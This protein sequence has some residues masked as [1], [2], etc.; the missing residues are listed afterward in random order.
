MNRSKLVSASLLACAILFTALI[1]TA[2][3]PTGI[4]TG[5]VTDSS[6]AVVA[7]TNI[8]ITNKGTGAA[9]TAQSNAEGVYS[10]PSLDPG[11]YEVRAENKG[12]STTV[13]AAGV[14]AGTTITVNMAMTVGAANEVVTVEAASAQI[15]YESNT[16]QGVI[17]RQTIQDIPLNGRSY[18][19]LASLE[20]GVAMVAGATSQYNGVFTVSILGGIAGR[21]LITLD[22]ANIDDSVQ[23]GSSM[24]FSQ[25]VVQEFQLQALNSDLSTGITGSGA[26]NVVTRSG[27]NDF[28]GGAYF[29]FRDHNMAAYPGL[30]RQPLFPDPFFVRRNP[31]FTLGGPA[32]KDKLFFFFNYEYQNQVQAVT[33]QEDLK[34]FQGL[35]GAF[36]S[37]YHLDTV[38]GRVDYHFSDRNNFFLRYSHDGNNTYGP[39]SGTPLPSAWLTN[40]NYADQGIIGLTSII[41]PTLVNDARISFEFWSNK[42]AFPSASQCPAPC[43]GFGLPAILATVG[44]ST[45][46][47]GNYA[48]APQFRIVRRFE[49]NDSL[50]WQKGEHRFRFGADLERF[51]API[52]W[53]FCT[54]FCTVLIS[55]LAPG[56]VNT[57]ADL[58]NV[59]VYN[60]GAGIFSGLGI[61]SG[62]YP[63]VYNRSQENSNLR[64]RVYFQDTWKL[65]PNLTV[66]YGV[67]WEYESGLFN[68]DLTPPAFLAPIYGAGNLHPTTPQKDEFQPVFGFAWSPGKSGKTVIRGGAGMYWETNYYFEKWRGSA[69]YGPVG[70]AR[71]TLQANVLSNTFPGIVNY[72]T[73][74]PIPVGAPLPINQASNLTFGQ[75]ISLYNAQIGVLTQKFSPSSVPT[76]GAYSVSGLDVAKTAIELFPPNYVLG[77]SYQTSLGVQ[78]DLGHDLVITAD[79]ARRQGSHFN[80]SADLDVNHTNVY[81]GGVLQQGIIPACAPA[82]Y[83]PGVECVNGPINQWMPEGRSIYEGLLI[84]LTKR[85]SKNYQV[86]ASYAYQNLNTDYNSVNLFNYTESYGPSLARQ[87]LNIAAIMNLPYGF[88]LTMNTQMISRTPVTAVTTGV[89]LSGTGVVSNTPLPG[90]SYNC[91]GI[92]CSKADLAAAVTQFNSTYA[93]TKAPNGAVIPKY[94]LPSDYQLGDPTLSQDFRLSR[95]FTYKER[96][97]LTLL[98]EAFNAFNIANLKGYTFNLDTVN[99][100]PANQTFAFGQ[101]TQRALQTFGSGGPRAFQ[102]GARFAF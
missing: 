39:P 78:R 24:N 7:G 87:N 96:Y 84:K 3:S 65:R 8:T 10:A 83:T 37:P 52:D 28:H 32:K 67:A 44:S 33:V 34:I 72:S 36:A 81:S 97:S 13:R 76:S 18:L 73:G 27:S 14:Q 61:G 82:N 48:N 91:L 80:L 66:N 85:M 54:P 16:I 25:E 50:Q 6:G 94:I 92:S 30:A 70:D 90:L 47:A 49:I 41:R 22:G 1:A 101:P 99:A 12:F 69:E 62:N 29:F 51:S 100:N 4:I 86:M 9:R 20:P 23:G 15:N 75:M 74:Q 57:T 2:Q 71:L 53:E 56:P 55:S 59:P 35:N 26:I 102:F 17:A 21:T 45:F 46:G 98:G 38:S 63:G 88:S 95:K 42:N 58:L 11:E 64:P 19:Q 60:I 77:R 93:G 5:T 43:V 40:T 68:K 89:D 79:W 31:G